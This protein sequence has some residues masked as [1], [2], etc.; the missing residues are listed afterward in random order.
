MSKIIVPSFK[1]TKNPIEWYKPEIA[2]QYDIIF[3]GNR[4]NGD[5]Q[6]FL[7]K[8][9]DYEDSIFYQELLSLGV[10]QDGVLAH[11]NEFYPN[12]RG[13]EDDNPEHQKLTRLGIG[14]TVLEKI[15]NDA[16]EHNAKVM[17]V[18]STGRKSMIDFLE[19]NDFTI[20]QNQKPSSKYR[21]GYKVL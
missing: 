7:R 11:L 4:P 9:S 21:Q 2:I 12:G 19:K 6:L 1:I 17:Y 8:V 20:C 13:L 3:N 16:L 14:K 10:D 18:F 5:A 15:T